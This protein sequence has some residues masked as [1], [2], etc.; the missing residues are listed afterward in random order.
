MMPDLLR[1]QTGTSTERD[2]REHLGACDAH[3]VPPLR[4]RV[5][6]DEYARKLA[7]RALTIE[8]WHDEVLVGLVAAY[9]SASGD[10]CFVSNVSVLP[11]FQGRGI[12]S[13][14]LANLER[15]PACANAR[16]VQLE[17]SKDS[18]DGVRLYE[19][20]GFRVTGARDD[21]IVMQYTRNVGET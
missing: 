20:V 3:F 16:S 11:E 18:V 21:Q 6:I 15:H 2:I 19:R 17:V 10:A 5:D 14:L 9:V 8:A 4:E 1:Y 12:A 13:A 7:E